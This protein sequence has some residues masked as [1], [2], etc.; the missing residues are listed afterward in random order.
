M[1]AVQAKD[2]AETKNVYCSNEATHEE[3]NQELKAQ[4]A[5]QENKIKEIAAEKR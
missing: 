5:E 1:K 4:L 2:K 3:R